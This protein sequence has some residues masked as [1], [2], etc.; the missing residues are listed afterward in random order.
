MKKIKWTR[1]TGKPYIRRAKPS[2]TTESFR[3]LLRLSTMSA[4]YGP[5]GFYVMIQRGTGGS[6]M[7]CGRTKKEIVD[8]ILY[9]S[10]VTFDTWANSIK[11][12]SRGVKTRKPSTFH[13]RLR[14]RGKGYRIPDKRLPKERAGAQ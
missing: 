14:R 11:L 9:C 1:A 8:S 5:R 12:A 4:A 10:Y 7:A 13:R 2:D 6:V 3:E